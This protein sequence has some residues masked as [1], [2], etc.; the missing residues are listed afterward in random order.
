MMALRA[1]RSAGMTATSS[2]AMPFW[3]CP[4]AEVHSSLQSLRVCNILIHPLADMHSAALGLLQ[5]R[6]WGARQQPTV[7]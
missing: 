2:E 7:K 5:P 6:F 4:T 1:R 3:H